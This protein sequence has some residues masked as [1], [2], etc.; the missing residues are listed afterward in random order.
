MGGSAIAPRDRAAVLAFQRETGELLRAVTGTQRV[1]TAAMARISAMKQAVDRWP[2]A[3]PALREAARALEMRLLDLQETLN[4]SRTRA[5][6]AEPEMPGIVARV[7][8][9]VRRH[10]NGMHGPTQTHREQYRIANDAFTALYP[11]MRQLIETD[12]PA[13]EGR[14]EDAGVP[15]TTGRALPAWPPNG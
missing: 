9:V 11:N 3:D 4:G 7:N 1:A 10:W 14:L 5:S 13:L 6:R 2:A 8:Q 12:L 15:W